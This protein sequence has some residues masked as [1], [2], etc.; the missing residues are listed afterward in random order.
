MTEQRKNQARKDVV[1]MLEVWYM[2]TKGELYKLAQ[3]SWKKN[4][5]WSTK[6]NIKKQ[7]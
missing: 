7:T 4:S 2:R 1:N 3:L 5:K 6:K